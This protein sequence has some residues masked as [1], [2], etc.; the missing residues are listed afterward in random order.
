MSGHC[1]SIPRY[2]LASPCTFEARPGFHSRGVG[3]MTTSRILFPIAIALLAG[4]AMG[5]SGCGQPAAKAE[6]TPVSERALDPAMDSSTV[7]WAEGFGFEAEG[8]ILWLAHDG[9]TTR[10][11]QGK[12]PAACSDCIGLPVSTE[13]ELATWSTTHVPFVRAVEATDLWVA[14]GYLSRIEPDSTANP[15]DLGGDAGMDE[16]RLLISGADVLTSYPFGD[17]MTGVSQRTGVP[18][19]AMAEYAEAHPL[20]RAE[21]VKVFGWLTGHMKEADAVFNSLESAYLEAKAI[22]M[23]E[24]EKEGRPI[25]FTGSSK[26]GK[27][28]APAGDG[29]VARLIADAGGEYAFDSRRAEALGLN[30]VGPNYEVEAEQCALF[31]AECDAFGKVVHA[32]EGWTVSD[33]RNEAPWFDVDGRVVFHCNTAEVDYFGQAILEPHE[34]LA[35]LVH[36]LHPSSGRRDFVYFQPTTP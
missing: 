6:L 21:F 25:V 27:W 9:D 30:R 14:S 12:I 13:L 7:R 22:A 10:W 11:V 26:G 19:M 1:G 28:T 5:L 3:I 34:M 33:A 31:A 4:M 16:E 24:A 32:P 20:G 36:L 8:T 15:V 17:P 29:L 35:D 18:V 2:G 23:S